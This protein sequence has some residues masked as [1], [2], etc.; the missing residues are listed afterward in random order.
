MSSR[1]KRWK[2]PLRR[3]S[4]LKARLRAEVK[5]PRAT[6]SGISRQLKIDRK[7]VYKLLEEF[8]LEMP[9]PGTE[10]SQSALWKMGRHKATPQKVAKVKSLAH[11]PRLSIA[12]IARLTGV[13]AWTLYNR[14]KEEYDIR[15]ACLEKGTRR[16]SRE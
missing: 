15:F 2:S 4:K 13:S 5:K 16:S 10:R 1:K 12:E 6:V 11:D 9:T 7:T 3:N 14:W 8:N